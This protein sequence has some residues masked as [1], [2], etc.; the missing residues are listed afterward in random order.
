MNSLGD[1]KK[2]LCLTL[3]CVISCDLDRFFDFSKTTA[4]RAFKVFQVEIMVVIS[5]SA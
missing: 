3:F 4:K 5:V 2:S 1:Y